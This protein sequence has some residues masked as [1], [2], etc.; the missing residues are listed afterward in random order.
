MRASLPLVLT[1]VLEGISLPE[2]GAVTL[3]Y[4]ILVLLG[5]HGS[6]S[7]C[8]FDYLILLTIL[9]IVVA[10]YLLGYIQFAPNINL[11]SG[12]DAPPPSQPSEQ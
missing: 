9:M 4:S 3:V 2:V 12:T 8:Y 6:L 10:V 7:Y 5:W 1:S 11:A